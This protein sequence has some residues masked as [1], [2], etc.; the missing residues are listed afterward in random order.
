ML[1]IAQLAIRLVSDL[2]DHANDD[3]TNHSFLIITTRHSKSE[4]MPMQKKCVENTFLSQMCDVSP[5]FGDVKQVECFILYI[6]FNYYNHNKN[7]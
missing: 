2:R 3:S 1:D 7:V 6:H 5:I 4:G